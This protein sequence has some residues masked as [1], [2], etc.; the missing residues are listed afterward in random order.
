MFLGMGFPSSTFLVWVSLASVV[1]VCFGKHG[2]PSLI[3]RFHGSASNPLHNSDLSLEMMYY[4]RKKQLRDKFETKTELWL[5]IKPRCFSFA[6]VI[7]RLWNMFLNSVGKWDDL[8]EDL[9]KCWTTSELCERVTYNKMKLRKNLGKKWNAL[10]KVE[11]ENFMAKS[12]ESSK[13]YS[14]Q[15]GVVPKVIFFL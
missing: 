12:K 13:Q 14:L 4:W 10:S 7:S 2:S 1:L 3:T 11:K 9:V 5:P 6:T 8:V 15:K